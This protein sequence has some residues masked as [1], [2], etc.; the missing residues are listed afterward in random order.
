MSPKPSLSVSIRTRPE[1]FPG[2]IGGAPGSDKTGTSCDD[3][4]EEL[5]RVGRDE[6]IGKTVGRLVGSIVG[7]DIGANKELAIFMFGAT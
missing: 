6:L 1:I 2:K 3:I 7:D 5:V 4:I